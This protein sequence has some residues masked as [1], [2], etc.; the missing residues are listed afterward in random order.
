[1]QPGPDVAPVVGDIT[2]LS[3]RLRDMD[4]MGVDIQAISPWPGFLNRDPATARAVNHGM[5]EAVDRH[6][7]RFT[8]LAAVPM[9]RPNDAVTELEWAI[10]G[11]G[12]R[13]VEIGSHVGG[14]N[15][16]AKD[17]APF[18][19]KVEELDVPVFIHP[20]EV[21]GM[22]RLKSY[23][24]R[25]LVGNPTE[26]AVA[27]ASLIFG[28]VLKEFPR[29]KFYLAHGGG[30]CPYLLGR[31]DHGWKVRPEGK[32]AIE[33]T[34]SEYFK[35]FY[36]DSIVHSPSILGYLIRSVGAERI[37][38][39]TDYPFDMGNYDPLGVLATAP[40]V[41]E[42]ERERIHGANAAALFKIDG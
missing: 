42:S 41:S 6:P 13:G 2:D 12:L 26:T 4:T 31:W 3:V 18:Y 39:G 16:D 9:S 30:S 33:R 37:M 15:L 20:V 1:M 38:L 8:G 5:A 23:Y 32:V 27:A 24:L 22:G 29:L 19:A 11:L 35:L 25:N 10:K 40:N 34:P 36:F 17:F 21:L 7:K 14:T 28:G